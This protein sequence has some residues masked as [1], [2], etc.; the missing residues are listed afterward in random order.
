[1]KVQ[2][3]L[4][5]IDNTV[6]DHSDIELFNLQRQNEEQEKAINNQPK[7]S[8]DQPEIVREIFNEPEEDE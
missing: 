4:K 5:T 3:D 8:Y 1:L 2:L 7:S 6:I